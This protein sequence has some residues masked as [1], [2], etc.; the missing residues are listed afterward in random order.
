[1]LGGVE[2][3]LLRFVAANNPS[4]RLSVEVFERASDLRRALLARKLEVGSFENAVELESAAENQQRLLVSAGALVSLPLGFYSKKLRR[5]SDLGPGSRVLLPE[6]P[7]E[8][9]RAL[10]VLYHYG[11]VGFAEELGP[12]AG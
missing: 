1:M 7:S 12:S 9:G 4:L 2:A 6:E 8:Q 5:L 3:E 11:L 10:L